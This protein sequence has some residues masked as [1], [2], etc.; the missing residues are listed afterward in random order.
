MNLRMLINLN[1]A[2]VT[3]SIPFS[4]CM[5]STDENSNYFVTVHNETRTQIILSYFSCSSSG[6][7]DHEQQA[8]SPNNIAEVYVCG[9]L[10]DDRNVIINSGGKEKRYDIN[11]DF[12]GSDDIYVEESDLAP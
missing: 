6:A 2:V 11:P 5:F 12:W 9:S 10:L 7:K 3:L 1:A 8:I 4:G